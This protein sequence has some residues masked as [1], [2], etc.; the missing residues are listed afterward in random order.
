MITQ[1]LYNAPARTLRLLSLFFFKPDPKDYYYFPFFR[2]SVA[3]ICLIHFLSVIQDFRLI[4]LG[5]LIPMEIAE[6]FRMRFMPVISDFMFFFTEKIG[7]SEN[8]AV[9]LF[10]F[11]YI[12]S[13]ITLALGFLTRVSAFILL[14][15]HVMLS[16]SSQLFIYGVDAFKSIGLFYCFVFPVGRFYSIDSKLFNVNNVNPTPYRRLLQIH[17]SIVYFFSG[18]DKIIGPNWR[19]GESIWKSVHLPFFGTDIA[20]DYTF[21]T[22]FPI[23]PV[24]IGWGTVIVELFYPLFIWQKSTKTLWL[25]LVILMHITIMIS[26]NLY[27][28]ASLMIFLNLA[29][30][31]NLE[32]KT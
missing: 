13:C 26:L 20:I 11:F 17:M 32:K 9:N 15:L 1:K 25:Y 5:G 21:M 4:Y 12:T 29:A 28:F 22:H 10:I 31:L 30:F 14:L 27:F 8:A 3:V 24:L 23:I 6:L 2:L 16:Q 7:L 18:F 19:N